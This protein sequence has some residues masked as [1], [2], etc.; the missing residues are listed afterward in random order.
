MRKRQLISWPGGEVLLVLASLLLALAAA[1]VALAAPRQQAETA[2]YGWV[3]TVY[4]YSRPAYDD[5]FV[6]NDGELFGVAGKTAAIEQEIETLRGVLVKVWGTYRENAPDFNGRQIVVSEILAAEA[7]PTPT[8][9]PKTKP[10]A[11]I[12]ATVANLRSGPSTAYPRIATAYAEQI[13]DIVGRNQDS[14]WWQ[15]CCPA[16]RTLWVSASLVEASGP[17]A[18]VPVV[19]VT[20]PPTP[21][22]V[23]TEWRGE[24]YPNLQFQGTPTVRNDRSVDFNWGQGAPMSG[25]PADDF[26]VRWT[27]SIH[28]DQGN[29]RFYA[30]ADDGVRVWLDGWL[31]IDQWR[32]GPLSA[33]GDFA[34]VGEGPHTVKVEYFEQRGDAMVTVWWQRTDVYQDWRGEYYTDIYLQPP[35]LLIRN[36]PQIDF[37][38]GLGS[39]DPRLPADNFSVRWTR[40]VYFEA[41]DYRFYIWGGDGARLR[42]DGWSVIDNWLKDTEHTFQG[43][44]DAVGS[45]YHTVVVE[46]YHRGGLAEVKVTWE[47]IKKQGGPQP[48]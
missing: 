22:P 4:A 6:R 42:L 24:Y 28:F 36:D 17:L 12:T 27:R 11:L 41:G 44:F 16:G 25:F 47:R 20:P 7:Q 43:R 37:Y 29:Y 32:A 31:V 2:V 15:I 9:K 35:P 33:S 13:Y 30:K 39:P 38:W 3:G 21:T 46:W 23:I 45:G 26:T 1:S 19:P 18:N 34:N 8:P 14:S 5:Y 48:D 40:S 10:E